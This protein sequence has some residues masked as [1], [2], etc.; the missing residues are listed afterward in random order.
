MLLL[1]LQT[2]L[3]RQAARDWRLTLLLAFCSLPTLLTV[4]LVLSALKM[5]A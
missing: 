1:P 4:G 3:L 5:A 2:W